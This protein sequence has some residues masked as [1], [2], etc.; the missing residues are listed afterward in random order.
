MDNLDTLLK[1]RKLKK[2]DLS[3]MLG[4]KKQNLNSLLRNPTLESIKKIAS[5]LNVEAWELFVSKDDIIASEN[6]KLYCIIEYKKKIYKATS[7]DAIEV[8]LSEIRDSNTSIT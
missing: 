2:T 3:K 4:I 5:I 8:I 6:E 1:E 7:I